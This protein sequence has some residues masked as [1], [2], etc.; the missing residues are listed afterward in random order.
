MG[1]QTQAAK[2]QQEKEKREAQLK[3]TN[4]QVRQL[5]RGARNV[6]REISKL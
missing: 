6:E 2:E 5:N 1:P 4:G 3:E